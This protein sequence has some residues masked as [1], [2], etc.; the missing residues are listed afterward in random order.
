MSQ[1]DWFQAAEK[2]DV[3]PF[4]VRPI[5]AEGIHPLADVVARSRDIPPGGFLVVDAPF[6]PKPLRRQLEKMGFPSVARPLAAGHWRIVFRHQPAAGTLAPKPAESDADNDGTQLD[7]CGLEP[8]EPLL[9]IL[10]RID[11]GGVHRLEVRLEREPMMLFP[12]LADRGWTWERLESEAGEVRL[13]L[14][15]IPA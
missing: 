7:L 5:L 2:T 9:R 12:E 1:S 8:P 14:T 4:D 13:K 10:K 3:P 6:D 11:G 15:L